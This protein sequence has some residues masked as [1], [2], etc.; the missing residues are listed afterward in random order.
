MDIYRTGIGWVVIYIAFAPQGVLD[1]EDLVFLLVI[2]EKLI[3]RYRRYDGS[4]EALIDIFY[5]LSIAP[6]NQKIGVLMFPI[7]GIWIY[8]FS[9]LM[10]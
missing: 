5:G 7:F 1:R 9:W 10:R 3:W 6:S 2:M 4:E 8:P